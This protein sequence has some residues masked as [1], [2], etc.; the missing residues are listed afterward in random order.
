MSA[1]TVGIAL[2]RRATV[3]C[4]AGP[5]ALGAP[6]AIGT[7][8]EASTL[9]ASARRRDEAPDSDEDRSLDTLFS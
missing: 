7:R 6:E 2:A 9:A 8:A 5:E 4:A 1:G 3:F